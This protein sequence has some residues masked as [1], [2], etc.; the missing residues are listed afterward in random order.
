MTQNENRHDLGEIL[1]RALRSGSP[2]TN[3]GA[4]P[5]DIGRLMAKNHLRPGDFPGGLVPACELVRLIGL[6]GY[7]PE[8]VYIRHCSIDRI[9]RVLEH[10]TDRDDCS[11][12]SHEHL[13][14]E[15][16]REQSLMQKHGVSAGMTTYL[17]PGDFLCRG[18]GGLKSNS[19]ILLVYRKEGVHKNGVFEILEQY[20]REGECTPGTT[21]FSVFKQHP[22]R[23]LVGVVSKLGRAADATF[24][25]R[26]RNNYHET[27]FPLRH[28]SSI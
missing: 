28:P 3:L 11:G 22:T 4:E 9:D 8:E 24:D 21:G 12:L 6:M 13:G 14:T 2:D 15:D 16:I 10:G 25:H 7:H 1:E 26:S 19:Q 5:V 18:G 27:G 20:L 17:N 23:C